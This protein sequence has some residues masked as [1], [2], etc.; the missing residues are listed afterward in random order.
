MSDTLA[1][2]EVDGNTDSRL[3]R[4]KGLFVVLM[5]LAILSLLQSR[6][7]EW[8]SIARV[9]PDGNLTI[10][11]TVALGCY[12][13]WFLY[14][15]HRELDAVSGWLESNLSIDGNVPD[16][17]GPQDEV[18]SNLAE[19]LSHRLEE[20]LILD[21][22]RY[23]ADSSSL[24]RALDVVLK[25]YAFK[26]ISRDQPTLPVL[27]LRIDKTRFEGQACWMVTCV[28]GC[29]YKSTGNAI[30]FSI[31]VSEGGRDIGP[32]WREEWDMAHG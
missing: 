9:Q 32:S 26:G 10:R 14:S 16:L 28:G 22:E 23:H 19:K 6:K 21:Y 25:R 5:V 30:V 17:A 13:E 3:R 31:P 8:T 4:I 27:P 7:T 2:T 29:P 11:H 12:S 24:R 1:Q 15:N 18:E 20:A